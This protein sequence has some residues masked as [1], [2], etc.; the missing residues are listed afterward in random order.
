M[1]YNRLIVNTL[2]YIKNIGKVSIKEVSETINVKTATLYNI[3]NAGTGGSE[4]IYKKLKAAFPDIVNNIPNKL[5]DPKAKYFYGKSDVW[6]E[7][8]EERKKM[9]N[10]LEDKITRQTSELA[11]LKDRVKQLEALIDVRK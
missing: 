9:I 8:A 6:Q 3:R 10:I 7:L 2:D 1:D 4:D 11:E 5:E